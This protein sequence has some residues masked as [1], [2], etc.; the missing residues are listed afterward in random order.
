MEWILM[1]D[2]LKLNACSGYSSRDLIEL[3]TSIVNSKELVGRAVKYNLN[4]QISRLYLMNG[5]FIGYLNALE[6]TYK[7]YPN[8]QIINMQINTMLVNSLYSDAK[9]YIDRGR[10]LIQKKR[11]PNIATM[12][13]EKLS[14]V[15][16]NALIQ[17]SN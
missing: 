13:F 11:Q 1:V 7:L 5:N 16:Q 6:K 12:R 4:Y 14:I 17:T 15:Y 10:E 3:L 9:L 8:L 2:I